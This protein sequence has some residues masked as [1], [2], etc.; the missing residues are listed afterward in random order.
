[1]TITNTNKSFVVFYDGTCTL[2]QKT[3]QEIEKWDKHKLLTWRSIEDPS[4]FEEY[5]FLKEDRMKQEM[6]LLEEDTYLYTGFAAVKRIFQLFP[7]GKRFA[8]LFYLPGAD[9]A[10]KVIYKQIAKRRHQLLGGDCASG[11]CKIQR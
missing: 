4:I 11:A 2:C 8:F 9:R 3:K 7:A 10:G 5:S 1:M 6:H